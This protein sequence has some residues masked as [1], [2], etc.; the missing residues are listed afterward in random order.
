MAGRTTFLWSLQA[1]ALD[2]EKPSLRASPTDQEEN[3]MQFLRNTA[4]ALIAAFAIHA[5][6]TLADEAADAAKK[7]MIATLGPDAAELNVLP[8]SF[9]A[10]TWAQAR[11]LWIDG[12]YQIP[13]KYRALI[14]LAVS[15]QIPCQFCIYADTSDAKVFGAS[16]QEIKEAVMFAAM[17]RQ[18]STLMNGNMADLDAYKKEIDAGAAAMREAM[19]TAPAQ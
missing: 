14:S 12:H 17:T 4:L 18:W 3:K 7:D 10:P 5:G 6:P 11:N 1:A 19:K 2:P 16:E 9:F 13:P 15:A 8:D